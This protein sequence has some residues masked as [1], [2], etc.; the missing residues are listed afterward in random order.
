MN[1]QIKNSQLVNLV[2]S[3][4]VMITKTKNIDEF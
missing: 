1:P 4:N 2:E 3:S